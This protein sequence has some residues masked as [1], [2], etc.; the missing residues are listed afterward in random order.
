MNSTVVRLKSLIAVVL[1]L[2]W[3]PATSHCL[4][5]SVGILQDDGCCRSAART[6]NGSSHTP[7]DDGCPALESAKYF[8]QK[9]KLTDLIAVNAL[10]FVPGL[11]LPDFALEDV[12]HRRAE[13]PTELPCRWQFAAR[14]AWPPRAPSLAS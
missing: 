5:G 7:I 4:L 1:V 8:V 12:P 14:T 10:V 13:V 2:V 9:H 6:T 3:I 11:L